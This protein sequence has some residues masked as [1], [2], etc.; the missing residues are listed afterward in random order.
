[1]RGSAASRRQASGEDR[2]TPLDA[3]FG[4]L[5]LRGHRKYVQSQRHADYTPA[6][7]DTWR[8]LVAR[9]QQSV[10]RFESLVHPEYVAG[11]RRWV[12][13]SV[14]I[15]DL[16]AADSPLAELGWRAIC[17]KGYLPADVYSGLIARGVFPVSREIRRTEH[18]DFSPV[19]DLA[20]DLIGHIPM[21]ASFE[22]RQFLQR[23]SRAIS[24]T[25]YSPRDREL[26]LAQRTMAALL[27]QPTCSPQALA[28]AEARVERAR[29]ALVAQPSRLAR[30]DRFYLWSIE[31]GLLG[32]PDDF[33]IY[34]AGLLSSPAETRALCSGKARVLP[35]SEAVTERS[36]E[37][38][39][40]QAVY[41]VAR[42]HAELDAMLTEFLASN[43]VGAEH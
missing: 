6:E 14:A 35:F 36:I 21:L 42:D 18:L 31:F 19:P 30:L 9:T 28:A 8:Q 16:E 7:H 4:G 20:H 13:P 25:P 17:V 11:F 10:D 12:Q 23:L 29:V 38:S 5:P 32:S 41:Y 40:H 33:R 3:S 27:C 22:H 15:P 24:T 1:V 34:G 39:E 43:P 26:Y 2:S 37:F